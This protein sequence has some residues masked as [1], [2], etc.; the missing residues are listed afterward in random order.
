MG[1]T[2]E[3]IAEEVSALPAE[4]KGRLADRL[5]TILDS[6]DDARIHDPWATEALR[7]RDEVRAGEVETISGDEAL[8][9]VR[10]AV[11]L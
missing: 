2:V 9:K 10:R 8:A 7:R 11:G 1:L 3:Q 5:V 4:E 6:T